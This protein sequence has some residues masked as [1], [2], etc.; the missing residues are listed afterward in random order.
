M[1]EAIISDDSEYNI[2]DHFNNRASEILQVYF[3]SL[4]IRM[5]TIFDE[6]EFIGE[7]EDLNELIEYQLGDG[8]VFCTRDEMYYL[9]KLH[10]VYNKYIRKHPHAI[11]DLEEVWDY[12]VENLPFKKKY[13][14]ENL[15]DLFKT[16]LELFSKN[17]IEE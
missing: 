6:S 11:D 8:I 7:P 16:N 17:I 4:G 5:E 2:P 15:I 13:L 3:K 10:K 9:N 1:Y 14:T 12:I